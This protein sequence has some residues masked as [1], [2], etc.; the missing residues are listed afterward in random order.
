MNA[1]LED[2]TSDVRE[3]QILAIEKAF[4]NGDLNGASQLL[5][6]L[7]VPQRQPVTLPGDQKLDDDLGIPAVPQSESTPIPF[8]EPTFTP[9]DAQQL[10][11][12]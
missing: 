12:E 3:D 1:Y 5:L 9:E 11:P 6:R 2:G 10:R 4:E 8:N 7:T